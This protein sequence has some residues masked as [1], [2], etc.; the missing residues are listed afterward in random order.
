VGFLD[1]LKPDASDAIN[2]LAKLGVQ[3]RLPVR[4]HS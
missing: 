1:P 4:V 2:R 3:V